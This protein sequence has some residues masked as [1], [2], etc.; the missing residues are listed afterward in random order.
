MSFSNRLSRLSGSQGFTLIELL[1]VISII[2]LLIG[3]LLPAL[4][5]ARSVARTSACLS[6]V[7]Q[8]SIAANTFAAEHKQHTQISSTDTI[9]GN[10]PVPSDLRGKV[11]LY[12]GG[13][14]RIKDWASA[15]VPFMGGGADDQFDKADPQVS[16]A[17][18]CPSDP[19]E[20]GHMVGNNISSGLGDRKPISYAVNADV[21]TYRQPTDTNQSFWGFGQMIQPEGGLPV[22][23]NLDALKSRSRVMLFADGGTRKPGEDATN[24]GPVNN[25]NVL[26]YIGIPSAWGA[27]ADEAGTFRATYTQL[28]ARPKLPIRDNAEDEDRHNNG[29]SIA[30]ADGHAS[31]LQPDQFKDV[32]MSPH[33]K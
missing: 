21:T 9:W 13:S 18:R 28:W 10:N 25:G 20:G 12:S 23:G 17:F 22:S 27:P 32:Y 30:F 6:N 24:P 29:M 26:M 1:V 5:A 33:K 8:M 19:H 14:S 7:R 15:L 4:G 11:S 16:K 31:N 3:L 2:A